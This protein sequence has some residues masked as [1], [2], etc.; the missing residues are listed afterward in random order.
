MPARHDPP[1]IDPRAQ[2]LAD[3]IVGRYR[4]LTGRR[5]LLIAVL[6]VVTAIG[7][8]LLLLDP[9][10]GVQRT[11]PRPA[12]KVLCVNGQPAGCIEDKIGVIMVAPAAS[13]PAPAAS[14]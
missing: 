7:V 12:D 6:A 5:R 1:T 11:R 14:R 8:V 13:A 2:A 9:P 4:P 3:V 10:G